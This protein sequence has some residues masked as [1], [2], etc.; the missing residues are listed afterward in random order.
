MKYPTD[1]SG[2][3]IERDGD[4]LVIT[5]VKPERLNAWTDAMRN[6]VGDLLEAANGDPEVRAVVLT[7]T[8][9]RSFCAGADLKELSG[10]D[11][12]EKDVKESMKAWRKF[13]SQILNLEKPF[14]AALN[15][16]AAGSGFQVALMADFRVAHD[17]VVMGQTEVISGIPSVT[18]TTLMMRRLGSTLAGELAL[19][20]RMMDS[21]ELQ[22]HGLIS[23]MVP[24]G[25]VR[26]EAIA[27][28]R[29]MGGRSF[30]AMKQTKAWL[31]QSELR[32][33]AAAFDFAEK[34]QIAALTQGDMAQRISAFANKLEKV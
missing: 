34:A 24:A 31:H 16:L 1:N 6:R 17:G 23:R 21:A 10:F 5:L 8:G 18:G 32:D 19:S 27:L 3:R 2:V 28:A 25:E 26:K 30:E 13:Y 7:G 14:V 29:E 11:S 15:G 22:R 9:E 4:V 33:L 12:P 20:G